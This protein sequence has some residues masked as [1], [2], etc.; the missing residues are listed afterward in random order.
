VIPNTLRDPKDVRNTKGKR[1][2][3]TSDK[4]G[5]RKFLKE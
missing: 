5:Q 2:F 3:K 4:E 1:R